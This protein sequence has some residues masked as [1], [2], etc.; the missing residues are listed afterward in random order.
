MV[1]QVREHLEDLWF[2]RNAYPSA[3]Q[4][5]PQQI[6][7]QLLEGDNHRLTVVLVATRGG[8]RQARAMTDSG[9]RAG[10]LSGQI[11]PGL[12]EPG[13]CGLHA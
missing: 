1:D 10:D 2:D 3:S 4:L 9:E 5:D 12:P 8:A 7:L 6:K 13:Q 11:S